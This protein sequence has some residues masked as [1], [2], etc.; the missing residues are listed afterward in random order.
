MDQIV[1]YFDVK[2]AS[3]VISTTLDITMAGVIIGLLLVAF[4][5]GIHGLT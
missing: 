5:Q 1:S 3:E 2:N 4:L